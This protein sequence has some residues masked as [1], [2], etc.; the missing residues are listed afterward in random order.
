[1][2]T[3][4]DSVL[5]V[6]REV[7]ADQRLKSQQPQDDRCQTCNGISI[8]PALRVGQD[9]SVSSKKQKQDGTVV[10]QTS[11]QVPEIPPESTSIGISPALRVGQDSSVSS[12]KQKQDGTVVDQTNWQVPEIHPESIGQT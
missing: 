10:D 6:C 12:K 11:W 9:S 2:A 3:V 4:L 8:S 5:H 1:M 7:Q